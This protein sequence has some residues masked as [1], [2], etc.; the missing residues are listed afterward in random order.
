MLAKISVRAHIWA[1]C[2]WVRQSP[3]R[4]LFWVGA[5]FAMGTLYRNF[6]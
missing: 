4:F 3:L 1:Y 5:G 6:F 2:A